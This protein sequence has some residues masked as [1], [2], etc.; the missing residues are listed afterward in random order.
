MDPKIFTR[1][2]DIV[3]EIDEADAWLDTQVEKGITIRM[4][5]VKSKNMYPYNGFHW[6]MIP[7]EHFILIDNSLPKNEMNFVMAHEVYH[8][9]DKTENVIMREIKANWFAFLDNK[10]GFF[11]LLWRYLKEPERIYLYIKYMVGG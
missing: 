7:T 9:F 11:K 2:A 6:Y 4:A 3:A 10:K 8:I 1:F 5:G